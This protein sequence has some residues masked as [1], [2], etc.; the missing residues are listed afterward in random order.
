MV[1]V[2][3][4]SSF[5]ESSNLFSILCTIVG[6]SHHLMEVIYRVGVHDNGVGWG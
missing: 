5:V 4:S 2:S 1:I 6:V 3:L